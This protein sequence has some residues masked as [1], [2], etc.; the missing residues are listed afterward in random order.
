MAPGARAVSFVLYKMSQGHSV[1]A[2]ISGKEVSPGSAAEKRAQWEESMLWGHHLGF[3][4][5]LSRREQF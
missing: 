3:N 2:D 5:G 4:P 1:V